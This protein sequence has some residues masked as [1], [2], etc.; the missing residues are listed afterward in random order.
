MDIIAIYGD[1]RAGKD[2][3]AE[4]LAKRLEGFVAYPTSLVIRRLTDAL[5]IHL[6]ESTQEEQKDA[7]RPH[8]T[9]VSKAGHAA[10]GPD[11]WLDLSIRELSH[12]NLRGAVLTGLRLPEN[13]T[14]IH[15]LNGLNIWIE[16]SRETVAKRYEAK[17]I[18]LTDELYNNFW[19]TQIRPYK[20]DEDLMDII[21]RNDGN[22][23]ETEADIQKALRTIT[24]HFNL[25]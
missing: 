5:D 24:E 20:N 25:V 3:I 17:G 14:A 4:E 6:G 23:E 2:Y 16:A 12:Q 13:L 1:L 15:E 9:Q 8:L 7:A 10:F 18:T 19:D 22:A 11:I 21:I